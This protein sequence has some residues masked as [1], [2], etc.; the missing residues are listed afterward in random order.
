MFAGHVGAALAIGRAERRINVGTF[1]FAALFLDMVL[2]IFVLRGWESAVIPVSFA[3]TH[4]PEFAFPYSHG[5]LAA[6]AWSLVGGA[7]IALATAHLKMRRLRRAVLAGAGSNHRCAGPLAVPGG[8]QFVDRQEAR[9]RCAVHSHTRFH[10]CGHDGRTAPAFGCG[11][12]RQFPGDD[13]RGLRDCV[14]ARQG[15]R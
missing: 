5:L 13:H 6:L 11:H 12:G 9:V 10:H 15:P 2:W 4:Q 7:A 14:L 8:R 1:V 3:N